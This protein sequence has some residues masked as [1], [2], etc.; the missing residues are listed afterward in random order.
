MRRIPRLGSTPPTDSSELTKRSV[1]DSARSAL[2]GPSRG[3][4]RHGQ[5]HQGE[6][7][8]EPH[9][10]GDRGEEQRDDGDDRLP[11]IGAREGDQQAH[12][13]RSR[14]GAGL[15]GASWPAPLYSAS[16]RDPETGPGG[17]AH[18]RASAAGA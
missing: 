10:L 16:R 17:A 6:E 1:P 18:L 14:P 3:R 4:S 9:A 2:D 11:G 15:R 8:G 12:G 7:G 13:D 5:V